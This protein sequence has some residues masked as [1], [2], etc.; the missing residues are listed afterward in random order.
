MLQ[1]V[2]EG[3]GFINVEV[4]STEKGTRIEYAFPYMREMEQEKPEI[5]YKFSDK[6]LAIGVGR[7]F[8]VALRKLGAPELYRVTVK[9]K[10]FDGEGEVSFT[11]GSCEIWWTDKYFLTRCVKVLLKI[12]ESV[13]RGML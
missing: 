9:G 4:H 8:G 3:N 1:K 11:V 7:I 12:E 6:N 10:S 5:G 2:L 13:F